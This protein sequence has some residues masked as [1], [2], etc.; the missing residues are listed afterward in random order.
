MTW[1]PCR[2]YF[3]RKKRN[4]ENMHLDLFKNRF[5][6]VTSLLMK[7][8]PEAQKDTKD[9]ILKCKICCMMCTRLLGKLMLTKGTIRT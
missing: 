5:I 3:N 4:R 1:H 7:Y 9:L 2:K 8:L 6:K